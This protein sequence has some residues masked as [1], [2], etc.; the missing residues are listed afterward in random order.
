MNIIYFIIFLFSVA[1]GQPSR[2]I[3]VIDNPQT[4]ED[5]DH[6]NK[7]CPEN[8][9]CDQIMGQMLLKWKETINNLIKQET[10]ESQKAKELEGF[11]SKFGIPTEF[12]TYERSQLGFKPILHS[13]PCK[14]HNPKDQKQKVYRGTSF[15]KS[16]SHEKIII[17]R[18]QTQIELPPNDLILPQKTIVYFE[19]G[20]ETYLLP[21]GDQPIYIQ[22][23]SLHILK[24]EDG[25]Y[26]MLKISPQGE[27]KIVDLEPLKL[28]EWESHRQNVNCPKEET[29]SKTTV[30]ENEFCKTVWDI[31][32]KRTV[33]IKLQNGC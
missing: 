29:P 30:F 32:K 5:F 27:W 33:V 7:G 19:S 14:S 11:R 21:L 25:F 18:D 17:W 12:Y 10:S 6:L 28:N 26:F 22:N 13:S 23:K 15:I 16:I 31:D 3:Q 2:R 9:E 24:E 8:S 20:P 4:A 1:M